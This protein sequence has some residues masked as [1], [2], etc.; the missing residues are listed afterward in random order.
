MQL[1]NM[2]FLVQKNYMHKTHCQYLKNFKALIIHVGS[3]SELS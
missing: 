1:S 2:K 3:N